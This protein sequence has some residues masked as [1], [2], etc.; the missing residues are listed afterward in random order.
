LWCVAQ[1]GLDWLVT[2]EILKEYIEV[3]NRPKFGLESATVASWVELIGRR[4]RLITPRVEI[5]FP[6]DRKDANFLIC[7]VSGAADVLITGDGDFS[8][9]QALISTSIMNGRQFAQRFALDIIRE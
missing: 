4:T 2:A 3:V 8:E 1:P 5:A 9:A 7:A 6:R